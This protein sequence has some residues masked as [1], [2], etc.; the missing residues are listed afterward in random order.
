MFILLLKTRILEVKSTPYLKTKHMTQRLSSSFFSNLHLFH[1]LCFSK[2]LPSFC[3]TASVL[4]KTCYSTAAATRGLGELFHS[5]MEE[6]WENIPP[7]RGDSHDLLTSGS[8]FLSFR[9]KKVLQS[10]RND[11]S[12]MLVWGSLGNYNFQTMFSNFSCSSH[13]NPEVEWLPQWLT[14]LKTSFLLL[15]AIETD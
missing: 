6:A 8:W 7:W 11:C 12:W 3:F 14:G 13:A 2:Y 9:F 5:V 10:C 4:S 1:L 15:H